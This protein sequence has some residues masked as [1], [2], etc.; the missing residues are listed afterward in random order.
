MSI[1]TIEVK[2]VTAKTVLIQHDTLSVELRDGRTLQV[3]LEWYPRL[4]AGSE[5]ERNNWRFIGNGEGIHW[6][7]LDE[8]ISVIDLIGGRP[9]METQDSLK[10]WFAKR[11][12]ER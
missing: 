5:K 6:P 2:D 1:F 11:T 7:E 10:K 9:S 8:D 3:P 12:K 4:L